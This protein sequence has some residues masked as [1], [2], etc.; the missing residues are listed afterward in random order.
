MEISNLSVNDY[1][2]HVVLLMVGEH[3]VNKSYK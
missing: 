1:T 3:A 2:T